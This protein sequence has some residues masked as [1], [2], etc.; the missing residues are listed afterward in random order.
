[1]PRTVQLSGV[2]PATSGGY[3]TATVLFI[4]VDDR[5]LVMLLAIGL[6]PVIAT[7][8][9]GFFA[10]PWPALVTGAAVA[11]GTLWLVPRL[12]V[13]VYTHTPGRADH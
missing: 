4:R 1:M 12:A 8:V 3:G 2:C 9:L 7:G 6:I 10:P 11:L 13:R 5:F